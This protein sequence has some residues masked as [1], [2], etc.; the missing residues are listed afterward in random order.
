MA[1]CVQV[2][3]NETTMQCVAILFCVWPKIKL[4]PLLKALLQCVSLF[5]YH[6]EALQQ[7]SDTSFYAKVD[8]D[9]T[10]TNQQLVKSTINDLIVKQEY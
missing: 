7:L 9:V 3:M 8:T 2:Q 4:K 1:K 6:M 5:L 10:S